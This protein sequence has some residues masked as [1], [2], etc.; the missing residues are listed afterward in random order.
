MN[1]FALILADGFESGLTLAQ[2]LSRF[3]RELFDA[4]IGTTDLVVWCAVILGVNCGMLGSFTVLRRQSLLGDAIGHAVLPGVVVGFLASSSR[5]TPALLI[6]AMTAGLIAAGMI[7]ALGRTTIL[8]SGECMGVVFTGMYALGIVLMKEAQR[9]GTP[10]SSGLERFLFGQIVGVS[11]ADVATMAGVLVLTVGVLVMFWRAISATSFD[12]EF[13]Q[14]VGIPARWIELLMTALVT[15]AIVISIQAVGVVLVAA[16]LVTPS[17]TAYLLTDRLARM[18]I[19]ASGIGALG[20]VLGA[21]FSLFG[22]NL[23][24]GAF[25]VLAVSVLFGLALL[26]GPDHGVIPRLV[27]IWRQRDRT[28]AENLIRTL[29]LLSESQRDSVRTTNHF[30]IDS[31]A[32]YRKEPVSLVARLLK[33]ARRRNWVSV[34]REQR[35]SLTDDGLAAAGRVVR[36]HRLWELFLTQEA[37]LAPD[38]VHADAEYI[39][40]M[41]PP[42]TIEKLER[43]L[44]HPVSDPHGKPI[45]SA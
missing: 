6:G 42:E 31:I 37:N 45:P 9:S 35:I 32:A 13:A 19:L 4:R 2:Q 3:A 21:F 39:E 26:V 30:T 14:S 17:A 36:S 43:M 41:L 33:A 28:R 10:G 34:D 7:S 16:M 40:H 29:Y 1:E 8:K 12:P 22:E 24:T 38:H 20:G 15:G 18:V 5:A 44:D 27:R 11:A 25:M 23:P